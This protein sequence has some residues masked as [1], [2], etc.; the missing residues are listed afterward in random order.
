MTRQVNAD[1]VLAGLRAIGTGL[2]AGPRSGPMASVTVRNAIQQTKRLIEQVDSVATGERDSD[3]VHAM[4]QGLTFISRGRGAGKVNEMAVQI[5]KMCGL[6]HATC[7]DLLQN[8]WQY[9][10]TL[11]Q[12]PRWE[13]IR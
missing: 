4:K 13:K 12:T 1:V 5:S 3:A 9:I 6:S 11:R 8:G 2:D 10:E 7:M